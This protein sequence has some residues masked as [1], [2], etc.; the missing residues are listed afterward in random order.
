MGII[1]AQGPGKLP[2]QTMINPRENDNV[3]T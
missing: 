3:M 2:S 1:E